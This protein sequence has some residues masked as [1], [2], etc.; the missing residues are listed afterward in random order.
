MQLERSNLRVPPGQRA[1]IHMTA[2]PHGRSHTKIVKGWVHCAPAWHPF[3][4]DAD[5]WWIWTTSDLTQNSHIDQDAYRRQLTAA[6]AGD[7]S[8]ADA[9]IKG[10][11]DVLGGVMFDCFDPAVHIV[12]PPPGPYRFVIGADWG[13]ASPCAALYLGRLREDIGPY[14]NGDIFVLDETETAFPDDL[15]QGTD[16]SIHTWAEMLKEM[17]RRNGQ[18]RCNTWVVQDDARGLAGDTVVEELRRCQISAQ[19]PHHKDR[20]GHWAT[21]RGLLQNAANGERPGLYFT[22]RCPNLLQTLPE[23]PRGL[24]RPEDL[25][26]KWNEDHHLDALAYGVRSIYGAPLGSG[27]TIGAH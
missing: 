17:M 19:R 18:P 7:A 8:L 27:R 13:T 1:H 6:T 24:L 23:A 22:S 26:P 12:T 20:V 25:D 11:W 9:W 2:N 21:I 15:S 4:D 3:K 10:S 14:R 16:A 5:E